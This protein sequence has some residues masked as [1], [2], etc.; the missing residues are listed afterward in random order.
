LLN[1][2]YQD[3]AIRLNPLKIRYTEHRILEGVDRFVLKD[4]DRVFRA[5]L[6][7]FIDNNMNKPFRYDAGIQVGVSHM[8]AIYDVLN[9]NGFKWKLDQELLALDYKKAI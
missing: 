8:E 1:V 4:R 7:T 6:Q 9:K 5:N 2:H 3:P